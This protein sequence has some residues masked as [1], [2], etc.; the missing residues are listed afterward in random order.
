LDCPLHRVDT[1]IWDFVDLHS[2]HVLI[3]QLEDVRCLPLATHW[4]SQESSSCA[5]VLEQAHVE[6]IDAVM[7]CARRHCHVHS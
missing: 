6:R 1:I 7:G 4:P 2:A 3:V 5:T